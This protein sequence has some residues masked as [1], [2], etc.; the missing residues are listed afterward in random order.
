MTEIVN[1]S[2]LKKSLFY[3]NPFLLSSN[4]KPNLVWA[5]LSFF[6]WLKLVVV[7]A[8]HVCSASQSA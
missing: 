3:C 1:E 7:M 6:Y 5:R 2:E 8:S 4:A